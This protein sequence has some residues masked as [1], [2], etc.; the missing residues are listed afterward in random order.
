MD[1]FVNRDFLGRMKQWPQADVDRLTELVKLGWSASQI[2]G[3]LGYT[4]NAVIG[5]IHRLGLQGERPVIKP[6]PP[7]TKKILSEDEVQKRIARRNE[8]QQ[9]WRT[10][11]REQIKQAIEAASR[12]EPTKPQNWRGLS[13]MELTDNTCRFPS[14]EPPFTYCGDP[15]AD[16]T[17]KRPYCCFHHN[18]THWYQN[19][20]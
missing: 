17:S 5:K 20:R 8:R 16:M 3:D 13:L 7:K 18:I 6:G 15:T 12:P 10:R 11:Q 19:G 2:G 4:R 1:Q 14:P 9:I